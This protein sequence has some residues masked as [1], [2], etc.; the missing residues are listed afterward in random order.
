MPSLKCRGSCKRPTRIPERDRQGAKFQESP[1]APKRQITRARMRQARCV[2]D[3]GGVRVQATDELRA[4]CARRLRGAPRSEMPG[5]FGAPFVLAIRKPGRFFG[6]NMGIG[7]VGGSA[8]IRH[9]DFQVL[10]KRTSF[11]G[12]FRLLQ[13]GCQGAF[14]IMPVQRLARCIYPDLRT[15]KTRSF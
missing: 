12:I 9:R 7:K 14:F 4:R 15:S 5:R 6:L 2:R 3:T 1:D 8:S 11:A 10:S 13:A